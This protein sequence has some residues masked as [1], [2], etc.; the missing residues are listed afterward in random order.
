MDWRGKVVMVAGVGSGLGSAVVSLLASAGAT[1]LAVARRE[2]SLAQLRELAKSRGW[3]FRGMTADLAQASEVRGL[4][5]AVTGEFGPLDGLSVNAGHWVE[6][7]PFLH[8]STDEEWTRGLADNLDPLF[9][10]CRAALPPMIARGRGAIVL[11]SASDRVRVLGTPSYDAAK[12]AIVELTTKLAHDYRPS[13]IRVN[14]VLPG[15]MEHDVDLANPPT[16]GTPLA[17]LDKSGSGAWEVA[18]AILFLLSEEARW[19]S[20]AALRVDGGYSTHGKE[21]SAAPPK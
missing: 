18:R 19:V 7:S 13:G 4:L 21:P 6:G 15:T 1:T 14:A 12:G 17:L 5:D 8:Q 2:G 20:G 10:L 11:V 16:P 3:N 9:Y